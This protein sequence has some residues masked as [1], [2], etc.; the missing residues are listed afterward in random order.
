MRY[1]VIGP[2]GAAYGPAD[3]ATLAQWAAEGR[4]EAS[5]ILR[6]E[7]SGETVEA[8]TVEGVIAKTQT[9]AVQNT[10]PPLL[11]SPSVQSVL[12]LEVAKRFNWGAFT[13]PYLW[14]PFHNQPNLLLWFILSFCLSGPGTLILCFWA[15]V[16]GNKWAW[17]SGRFSTVE[18]MQEC[19]KHWNVWGISVLSFVMLVILVKLGQVIYIF[20]H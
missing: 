14:G 13:F 19:Q 8:S 2:D 18:E 7:E 5:T 12:P 15:G 6:E 16:S 3:V 4:I 9:A 17:E 10:A 1:F 11:F 20:S